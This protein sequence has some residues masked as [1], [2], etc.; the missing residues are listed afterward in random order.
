MLSFFRRV[1]EGLALAL[2]LVA[3][4]HASGDKWNPT[5][6]QLYKSIAWQM[7]HMFTRTD[8]DLKQG[9]RGRLF[10]WSWGYLG[11]ASLL[12]HEATGEKRFLDLVRDTSRRLLA[13]RDDA[14]GLVDGERGIIMPSWQV[15]YN[16]G[17]RSNEITAAGLITL[18]MCQYALQT[19]D[20]AIGRE[21]V[22]SLTAFIS[23]RQE[24]HGGYYFWH[25]SQKIVEPLNHAHIYGAALAW[26]SKLDY[27]PTSFAETAFGIYR[28][29]RHFTRRDG[30][31][32]SWAYMPAPNSPRDQKSE[33]IWKMGVTIELPIALIRTGVMEDDG[34]M[35]DLSKT[36]VGNSIV[37]AGGIPQFLGEG[38]PIDISKLAKFE[39]RSLTGLMAPVVL[40]DDPAVTNRF[41]SMVQRYPKQFP[42]GWFGGAKSMTFAYAYLK[43]K[44]S[45]R[46]AV[47]PPIN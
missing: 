42:N 14:L 34:I 37:K 8:I 31:G 43:A 15:K 35:A 18:P 3:P 47:F 24:A 25:H 45:K 17:D 22:N 41:L 36:V 9:E 1:G 33:A 4:A 21:A 39:G 32:L 2:T 20:H 6:D 27:A 11:R 12:M 23:E 10:A 38:K 13:N 29:W 44:A 40:L 7:D 19:G 26:C 30:E 5:S 46:D 28:Y 16:W